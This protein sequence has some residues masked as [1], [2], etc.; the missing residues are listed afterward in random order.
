[1]YIHTHTH[2][3]LLLINMKSLYHGTGITW[4]L[5]RPL[6]S[7]V[8]ILL[9]LWHCKVKMHFCCFHAIRI[10]CHWHMRNNKVVM[11]QI[12]FPS[13]SFN[14][15]C[16]KQKK[17]DQCLHGAWVKVWVCYKYFFFVSCFNIPFHIPITNTEMENN[18]TKRNLL[19][20]ASI[21]N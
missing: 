15:S 16:G 19:I 1:M 10:K 8:Y 12:T 18:K 17:V 20:L 14:N 21:Q 3:F 4:S 9:I 2:F 11:L 5:H 6:L 7:V 13:V